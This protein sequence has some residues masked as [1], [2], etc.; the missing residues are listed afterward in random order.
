[1]RLGFAK[2]Q[3]AGSATREQQ[4]HPEQQEQYIVDDDASTNLEALIKHAMRASLPARFLMS[5]P[6]LS[7]LTCG[8]EYRS[9]LE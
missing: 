4:K 8:R 9:K 2:D 1:M 5:L 6:I 7:S 3:G